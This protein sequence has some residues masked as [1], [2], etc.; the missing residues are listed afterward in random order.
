M[1]DKLCTSLRC[2]DIWN[3]SILYEPRKQTSLSACFSCAVK[4][5]LFGMHFCLQIRHSY[6]ITQ[7]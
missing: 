2:L 1:A 6:C 5:I 3:S 4:G 7:L